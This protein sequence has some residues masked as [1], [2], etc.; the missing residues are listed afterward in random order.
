M[1]ERYPDVPGYKGDLDTTK[2]A[3]SDMQETS[4]TLR[5]M[6][7]S[8]LLAGEWTADQI[9]ELLE[10]DI[11][12]IR[13]RIS[14]LREKGLIEDTGLRRPNASGKLAAVWRAK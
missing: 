8:A 2:Q 5:S 12:S 13:P 1:S 4:G 10:R 14:E 3:A 11:L 9:A 6:C 7:M